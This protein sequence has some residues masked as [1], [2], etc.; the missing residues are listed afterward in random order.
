MTSRDLGLVGL[1]WIP[2]C[3]SKSEYIASLEMEIWSVWS[4]RGKIW[5]I[6]LFDI[7]LVF[8]LGSSIFLMFYFVLFT[9]ASK[10]SLPFES[11]I[12]SVMYTLVIPSFILI[13]S[14]GD[15]RWLIQ[16]GIS[17]KETKGFPGFPVMYLRLGTLG[18]DF[19]GFLT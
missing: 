6:F 15:Y 1:E 4:I 13:K 18:G 11:V 10:I 2:I 7:L 19:M 14:G 3:W 5:S 17:K 9:D 8:Y 16:S 12:R